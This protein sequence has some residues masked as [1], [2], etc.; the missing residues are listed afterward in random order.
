MQMQVI[1]EL[2]ISQKR[3]VSGDGSVVDLALGNIG[4]EVEGVQ[5]DGLGD[6]VVRV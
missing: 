4:V 2:S 3:T 6:D 5:A 1:F